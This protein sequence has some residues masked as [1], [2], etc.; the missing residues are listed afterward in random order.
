[1]PPQKKFASALSQRPSATSGT[2]AALVCGDDENLHMR[3]FR[4]ADEASAAMATRRELP[5]PQEID[6][7]MG[8]RGGEMRSARLA[9]EI[10]VHPRTVRRQFERGGLP[11]AKEHGARILTIPMYLYRLITA[12]G[13]R[14]VERMAKAGLI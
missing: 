13:M 9:R 14:G 6:L 1:M 2:F 8:R 7:V 3:H 10:G 12:Y 11:G 5:T 4:T